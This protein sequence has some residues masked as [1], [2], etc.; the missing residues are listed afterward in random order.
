MN[1]Q[2][3]HWRS[4]PGFQVTS[5]SLPPAAFVIEETTIS[6]TLIFPFKNAIID[7][8]TFP[9]IGIQFR[10]ISSYKL[11]VFYMHWRS[12]Q[13]QLSCPRFFTVPEV[14][15]NLALASHFNVH[16]IAQACP[17]PRQRGVSGRSLRFKQEKGWSLRKEW[18]LG[19]ETPVQWAV[20]E[21]EKAHLGSHQ[22]SYLR[23]SSVRNR[24]GTTVGHR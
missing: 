10:I 22:Q 15:S 3:P 7:G 20:F 2:K 17:N 24:W 9:R 13:L 1:S 4:S 12:H 18:R 11:Q 5:F 19:W 8:Q 21:V 14:T 16:V 6:E 23:E